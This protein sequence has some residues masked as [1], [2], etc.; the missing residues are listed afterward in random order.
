[1][2]QS[3]RC[4]DVTGSKDDEGARV[5]IAKRTNNANQRWRVVY[6]DKST[7]QTKGLDKDFGF[8]IG[9]PFYIHSRLPTNRVLIYRGGHRLIIQRWHMNKRCQK[10]VFDKTRTIRPFLNKNH[11]LTIR[12]QGRSNIAATENNNSRWW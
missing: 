2:K 10:W 11:A 12:N 6:K 9:R 5:N 1:M 7:T 8:E 4:L 3:D